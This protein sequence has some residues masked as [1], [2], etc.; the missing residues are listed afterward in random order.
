MDRRIGGSKVSIRC[1]LFM[2]SRF[3]RND[4]LAKKS[5]FFQVEV[6]RHIGNA[7]AFSRS[8]LAG[9]FGNDDPRVG[10]SAEGDCA[11][12]AFA[13][14]AEL[15]SGPKKIEVLKNVKEFVFR[16]LIALSHDGNRDLFFG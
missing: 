3:C 1:H 12:L 13:I 7:K 6:P 8:G 2:D 16:D 11:I 10:S 14:P 4:N 9:S 15:V 5:L